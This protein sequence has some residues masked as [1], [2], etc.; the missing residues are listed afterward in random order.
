MHLAFLSFCCPTAHSPCIQLKQNKFIGSFP[1]VSTLFWDNLSAPAGD[2]A[3][4]GFVCTTVVFPGIQ[5]TKHFSE[6][7]LVETN[8]FCGSRVSF[9][10]D[11][12]MANLRPSLEQGCEK[13]TPSA[14]I[15]FFC[16]NLVC[17]L[18]IKM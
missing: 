12:D 1:F 11:L 8:Q 14:I 3:G 9:K 6:L 16:T 5:F 18:N 15:L 4:L 10:L 17:F 2:E 7:V 13:Q